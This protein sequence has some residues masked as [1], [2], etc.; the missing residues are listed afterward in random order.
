MDNYS[1]IGALILSDF[2]NDL[3]TGLNEAIAIERGEIDGRITDSDSV[4][5][6]FITEGRE[7]GRNEV[8]RKVL[9]SKLV[10]PEQIAGIL[11]LSVAEVNKIAKMR[12]TEA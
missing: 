5:K 10:T 7:K 8:I 11:Q 1:E 2:Y 6:G 9:E 3:I 4:V 12:P